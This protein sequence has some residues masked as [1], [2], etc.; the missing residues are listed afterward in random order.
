MVAK[1]RISKI[2]PMVGLA[3]LLGFAGVV[4]INMK[5]MGELKVNGPI[6][7]RIVLGKDL[8]ADILP[9]PEYVIEAYLEATLVLNDPS[10]LKARQERLVQLRKDYDLRHDY[11]LKT[12]FDDKT[13]AML[14]KDAHAPA[15]KFWSLVEGA[16]LQALAKGDEAAAR[17]VYKDITAAYAEHRK[18]I[19]DTVA[20][21]TELNSQT[22]SMAKDL[23]SSYTAIVWTV[24]LA[25]LALICAALAGIM[26]GIVGPIG[27]MTEVMMKLAQGNTEGEI[28]SLKRTD[29]VGDMARSVEVF[30]QNLLKVGQLQTEQ[31]R[32]TLKAE[33]EKKNTLNAMA[34]T[35]EK[36]IMGVVS[37][38]SSSASQLQSAAQSLSAMAEQT[39]QQAATVAHASDNASANVQ[40]VA[41]ATEELSS[42]IG[43]ISHQVAESAQVSA[44]AVEEANRVNA[45]VQGLAETVSKIGAVVSLITDI[46]S[47]T[48]LLALNATIEAARAGDA[49]KGFAV[50][51]NEVKSLANQTAKATD[52][53]AAQISAVQGATHEAVQGIEG[54]TSTIGRISEIASS[55]AGAVEQQGAAT[56]EI[57]RSVQQ[58][59]EGTHEVSSNIAGVTNASTETGSAA[60]QVLDAAK[61]LSVQ[62]KHLQDDVDRFIGHLRQG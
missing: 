45:L 15:M 51:A 30:K 20:Y 40:T 26:K 32:L 28:P 27:R 3:V 18:V 47:Q 33:E 62:S 1:T 23:E 60:T 38:V 36:S 41:S 22:E 14:T 56:S 53:I 4:A 59:S 31:E 6:Y 7:E 2:A 29:E 44:G 21:T 35:F 9:P 43:E 37:A 55:I 57:S 10:S 12:E 58:A 42:S 16:F 49:G 61:G 24:S 17:D 34:D 19:D 54:I 11:W 25:I 5:A 46:A 13:R 48:N 8:I 52:E 50:V 39:H